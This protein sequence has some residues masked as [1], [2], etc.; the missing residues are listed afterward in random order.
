LPLRAVHGKKIRCNFMGTV[1]DT[2]NALLRG[3]MGKE[4]TLSAILTRE[5]PARPGLS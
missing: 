2:A 4:E 5:R 1:H 3:I